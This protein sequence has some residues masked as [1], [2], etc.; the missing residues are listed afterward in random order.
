MIQWMMQELL[1]IVNTNIATLHDSYHAYESQK[2]QNKIIQSHISYMVTVKL[3]FHHS[4]YHRSLL[5]PHPMTGIFSYVSKCSLT[6]YTGSISLECNLHP[7]FRDTQMDIFSYRQ[8]VTS[9][10]TACMDLW[11]TFV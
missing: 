10:S 7:W 5:R 4:F 6:Y 11:I 2:E 9:T 8:N 3:K 1:V